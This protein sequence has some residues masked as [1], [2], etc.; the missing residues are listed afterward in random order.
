MASLTR[1]W[2]TVNWLKYNYMQ[3]GQILDDAALDKMTSDQ[4]DVANQVN[5]RTEFRVLKTTYKMY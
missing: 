2:L 4:Q 5:R 3:E 1:W